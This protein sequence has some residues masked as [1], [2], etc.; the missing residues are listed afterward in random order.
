[1]AG[2]IKVNILSGFNG[3]GVQD[4][5]K[6]LKGLGD[7]FRGLTS[8]LIGS[9]AGFQGLSKGVEFVTSSINASRDLQ[10]NLAGL[11][12]IFG[13]AT[14]QMVKFSEAGVAMGMS[15]A[16]AAKATTFIGSVMKQSGFAMDDNI[17]LTQKLVTLGADLAATY[18]YDVQEALTGMT[19]LFRGE[20]DP[21]EKFGVAIKQAQVNAVLAENGLKN[22]TGQELLHAQQLI[23]AKLLLEATADAQGAVARQS[24]TLAVSQMQ[25]AA[26]WTNFKAQLGN[27]LI[28][29][30]T[31]LVKVIGTLTTVIGP[32]LQTLFTTIASMLV[33]AGGNAYGFSVQISN[34][35]K[36]ITIMFQIAAPI[37]GFL[38]NIMG[39]SLGPL[40]AMV[41]AFKLVHG[42][43]TGVGI[44]V[45]AFNTV[46]GIL[47]TRAG[48][49]AGAQVAAA[50]ATAAVGAASAGAVGPTAA[51]AAVT[52]L[53]PWGMIAIAIGLVVAAIAGIAAASAT[54]TPVTGQLADTLGAMGTNMATSSGGMAGYNTQVGALTGNMSNLATATANAAKANVI[55]AGTMPNYQNARAALREDDKKSAKNAKSTTPELDSINKMIAGLKG[56]SGASGA[57]GGAA[58]AAKA[59]PKPFQEAVKKIRDELAS[60]HDSLM[61][62]FDITSMGKSGSTISR[63]MS[64]LMAKMREFTSLI[65]QLRQKGLN[66]D[67]LTQIVKAGPVAGLDAAKALAG[68]D[69]LLQQANSSY[70]EFGMLSGQV[71]SETIQAKYGSQYNI[72]VEGGVGS[73]A[74]I[75]KAVVAA[76]QAFERQS[77]ANWRTT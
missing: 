44:A 72:T 18:G 23:R 71:A 73:G 8:Q 53:T 42:V 40:V 16:E 13:G 34:I 48:L 52:A 64:K 46:M 10:R 76:I 2:E 4:A 28:E 14:G 25:L 51:L 70:S 45:T 39:S 47:A 38:V 57:L 31:V 55:L 37:F 75:G 32:P 9:Y 69:S 41:T 59:L 58:K 33:A 1:M 36:M 6:N 20:Y 49:A 12:T 15:T 22:L 63:N 66:A 54:A 19:A 43:V 7:G 21:I 61:G 74:T 77:G 29:P 30:M 17:M 35:I 26:G 50:G 11:N 65:K 68:S 62:A 27:A 67:L 56:A 24:N 5:M 3:K 60:L